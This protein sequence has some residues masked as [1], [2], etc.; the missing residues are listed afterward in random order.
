MRSS[1][2]PQFF[3][4]NATLSY[5]FNLGGHD[6]SLKLNFNNILNKKDNFSKAYIS[7]AYGMQL[8]RVDEDGDISWDE[9]TFGEGASDGNSDGSGYYPYLSPSP[10]FNVFLTLEYTF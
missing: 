9:P 6:A 7:R 1:K 10:L 3:E 8:K 5:K 2:L 4:L